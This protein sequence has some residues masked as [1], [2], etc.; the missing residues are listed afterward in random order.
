[1][2]ENTF[3]FI[4]DNLCEF[5]GKKHKIFL[6][7]S[8]K[9]RYI[10]KSFWSIN[11]EIEAEYKLI[12]RQEQIDSLLD[13][14]NFLCFDFCIFLINV[15]FSN[16][17]F[18]SFVNFTQSTFLNYVNFENSTFLDSVSFDRTSFLHRNN[19]MN[20]TFNEFVDFRWAEF[21]CNANFQFATF[22]KG[23]SFHNATIPIFTFSDVLTGEDFI[24]NLQSAKID[25]IDYTNTNFQKA[26]NKETFLILKELA[27]KKHDQIGAL[28]FYKKEM[29]TH[30]SYLLNNKKNIDY[31][32]LEFEESISDFGTNPLKPILFII[33]ISFIFS[34]IVSFYTMQSDFYIEATFLLM[35]P[36]LSISKVM[37]FLGVQTSIHPLLESLNF[38]KNIFLGI[39]IYETIKSFRKFSRK[40]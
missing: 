39:L 17:E 26:K 7:E 35:N 37:E 38:F 16:R 13:N 21:S 4:N 1:V 28:N 5:E 22:E 30:K 19:F 8:T 2:K 33:C 20:T 9:D 34:L 12:E 31:F 6:N 11:S 32:I 24:L 18:T 25:E 15:D 3:K 27:L 10:L 36:T 40:L 14:S 23:L 29:Q